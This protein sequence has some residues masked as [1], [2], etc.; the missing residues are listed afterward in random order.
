VYK[1]ATVNDFKKK[2]TNHTQTSNTIKENQLHQEQLSNELDFKL[3]DYIKKSKQD[4][5]E[6]KEKPLVQTIFI[7]N[8][9]ID[10]SLSAPSDIEPIVNDKI[11]KPNKIFS[12]RKLA[13]II[14]LIIFIYSGYNL[15]SIFLDYRS[16]SAMNES[17]RERY[18]T[19]VIIENNNSVFS[20]QTYFLDVDWS[21]LTMR[22]PDVVGWIY[23]PNTNINYPLLQG[24]D[25]ERYLRRDLDRNHSNAGSLFVAASNDSRFNDL[26]TIIYGHNMRNNTKFAAVNRIA[27]GRQ[28]VPEYIHIYLPNGIL[29]VYRVVSINKITTASNLYRSALG[30]LDAYY[31]LMQ[32]GRVNGSSFM[33]EDINRIITLSTC[34]AYNA[35][36]HLRSVIY[37]ILVDEINLN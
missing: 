22:N 18:I 23:V 11:N 10:S 25:N 19:T 13:V 33:K 27:N 26:N 16:I 32:E 9:N 4:A 21:A 28:P 6:L 20:N 3:N 1:L 24:P 37:A 17:I 14:C 15:V 36:T 29:N 35:N 2:K 30:S 7:E 31:Q 12:I 34:G 5:E 8:W